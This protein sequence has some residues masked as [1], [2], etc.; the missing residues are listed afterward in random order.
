MKDLFQKHLPIGK[1]TDEIEEYFNR[2]HELI[3]TNDES[4]T[5]IQREQFPPDDATTSGSR[6]Y[7]YYSSDQFKKLASGHSQL[8]CGQDL[9]HGENKQEKLSPTKNRSSDTQ[10]MAYIPKHPEFRRARSFNGSSCPD[11]QGQLDRRYSGE[12]SDNKPS[13]DFRKL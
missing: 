4:K 9:G 10:D 11:I 5:P 6:E 1:N 13:G 8:E 3:C 7:W 12:L 2:L